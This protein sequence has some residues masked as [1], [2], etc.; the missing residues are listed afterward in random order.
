MPSSPAPQ[1]HVSTPTTADL[2]LHAHALSLEL[3]RACRAFPADDTVGLSRAVRRTVL[4]LVRSLYEACQRF[5]PSERV[6]KLDYVESSADEA[7]SL[8]YVSYRLGVLLEKDFRTFVDALNRLTRALRAV[9][10]NAA[11]EVRR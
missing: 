6:P 8:G 11:N 1:I 7:E 4:E 9:H 10:L 3:S 5:R 2:L